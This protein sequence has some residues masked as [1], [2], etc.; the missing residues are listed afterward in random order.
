MRSTLINP[1]QR[2]IYSRKIYIT[3]YCVGNLTVYKL[4]YT[5]NNAKIISI[6]EKKERKR[7]TDQGGEV[8]SMYNSDLV[9]G[10]LKKFNHECVWEKQ[11]RKKNIG[12]CCVFAVRLKI[13]LLAG[14]HK[15]YFWLE[16]IKNFLHIVYVSNSN[17]VL[18]CASSLNF[19]VW[20]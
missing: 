20:S 16:A 3:F 11:R 10:K 1:I 19:N 7:N 9:G 4:C 13:E 2:Y 8:D 12:M 5:V 15:Y 6:L 18:Y 14:Y 17:L